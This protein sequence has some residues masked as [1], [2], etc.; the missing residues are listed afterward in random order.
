[1]I[2]LASPSNGLMPRNIDKVSS[3]VQADITGINKLRHETIKSVDSN[4][5]T[6]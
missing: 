1:M 6:K 3:T 2:K 4:M 5:P